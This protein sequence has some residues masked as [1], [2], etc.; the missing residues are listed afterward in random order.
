MDFKAF[1][2]SLLL[3]SLAGCGTIDASLTVPDGSP[4]SP[5]FIVKVENGAMDTFRGVELAFQIEPPSGSPLTGTLDESDLSEGPPNTFTLTG[6][7]SPLGTR[8]QG[9]WTAR[10]RGVLA[11]ADRIVT[12]TRKAHVGHDIRLE[13]LGLVDTAGGALPDFTDIPQLAGCK[14]IASGEQFN[15]VV[16]A[17][18][19]SFTSVP[20]ASIQVSLTQAG[21][22][23]IEPANAI[24][25]ITLPA[26]TPATG[27]SLGPFTATLA[28]GATQAVVSLQSNFADNQFDFDTRNDFIVFLQVPGTGNSAC[29]N[30]A[31]TFDRETCQECLV[32]QAN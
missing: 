9:D 3:L 21:Q 2:A 12:R 28:Q 5:A 10:F 18:N 7:P 31:G 26:E 25:T 15:M 1:F 13:G 8:I 27:I 14:R 6:A 20:A 23:T 11:F 17:S 32:V 24:E 22:A 30:D 4:V 29:V 19:P 16:K